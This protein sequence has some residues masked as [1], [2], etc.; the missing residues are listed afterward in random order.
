MLD[1]KKR[2]LSLEQKLEETLMISVER[3]EEIKRL[4]KNIEDLNQTI[5]ERKI[6]IK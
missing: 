3:A 2:I 5:E 6:E 1:Y 4:L